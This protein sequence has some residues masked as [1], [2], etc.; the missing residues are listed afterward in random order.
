MIDGYVNTIEQ[1][2]I[3]IDAGV[4]NTVLSELCIADAPRIYD[5]VNFDV[6]HFTTVGE[7][8]PDICSSVEAIEAW[9]HSVQSDPGP[10]GRTELGIW[11]QQ[12]M[13]GCIGYVAYGETAIIWYWVGKEYGG[14]GYAADAV[15][16]LVPHLQQR[17][18]TNIQANVRMDNEGS[19]KTMQRS[20]FMPQGSYNN[21][22]RY[23]YVGDR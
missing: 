1:S 10:W 14:H 7:Q 2:R 4:H 20:G 5:L 9:L 22:I 15:Q 3:E 21:Y 6:D 23:R 12:T 19:K 17:G 18:H 8:V 11:Q 13:V 16:T